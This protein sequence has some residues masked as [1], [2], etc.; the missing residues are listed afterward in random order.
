[1]TTASLFLTEECASPRPINWLTLANT[2]FGLL[3]LM[4]AAC[5][6]GDEDSGVSPLPDKTGIEAADLVTGSPVTVYLADQDQ[7]GVN[8]LYWVGKRSVKLNPPFPKGRNVV[9]YAITP[10]RIGVVYLADQ[11]TNGVYELYRVDFAHPGV[12][13]KLSGRLVAGGG[14]S[15]FKLI[16]DGTGVVYK[17]DELTDG[18]FELFDVSFAAPRMSTRVLT[19]PSADRVGDFGITPD[20]TAIVL[21]HF[22]RV[23]SRP[24]TIAFDNELLYVPLATPGVWTR[25]TPR[26]DDIL[27]I[28]FT[29][30][31]SAIVYKALTSVDGRPGA[32]LFWVAFRIPGIVARLSQRNHFVD[33]WKNF[34]IT[35]DGTAVV[36]AG[37]ESEHRELRNQ[38]LYRVALR[39]PGTATRLNGAFVPGGGVR[40]FRLLH[41]SSGAVYLAD[42]DDPHVFELYHVSFLFP[43]AS[44]KLN[45]PLARGAGIDSLYLTPDDS[46]VLY[47]GDQTTPTVREL[48]RVSLT[49]PRISTKLNGPL[50]ASGGVLI[51]DHVNISPDGLAVIYNADQTTNDVFELY[52]VLLAMP[53]VSTKLNN[54]LIA[55][56]NVLSFAVQ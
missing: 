24:G 27:E 20:S 39:M 48:Y 7:D 29:P 54:P 33:D 19:L 8:E 18:L 37:W 50:V 9:Q 53:G 45:P 23:P 17:A 6:A 34:E 56:G 16:P 21:N 41:D 1:M 40:S 11:D 13:T 31:S 36:Y 43:G 4:L 3:A 10:D 25:L 30:D 47:V 32:G 14:V 35:P 46:A 22:I 52:R 2:L 26:H 42:Q 5:A 55:N 49:A 15:Y 28:L 51:G 44:T 38:N 12:S